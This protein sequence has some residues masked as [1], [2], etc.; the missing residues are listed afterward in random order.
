M[1][2]I[3]SGCLKKIP[4]KRFL[5]CSIC[6]QSYDLECA[7]VSEAQFYNTITVEHKNTWKCHFCRS[8]EPKTDNK[9]TPVRSSHNYESF[10]ISTNRQTSTVDCN[11]TT[12]KKTPRYIEENS[13]ISDDDET[14]SPHGNTQLCEGHKS[15]IIKKTKINLE[16]D[17]EQV[18]VQKLSSMLQQNNQHILSEIRTSFRNEIENAISEIMTSFKQSFD[19]ITAEQLQFKEDISNLNS[20]ITQLETNCRTIQSANDNLQRKILHLQSNMHLPNNENKDRVLILHG[21]VENYW[22]T[23]SEIFNRVINI[24]YDVLNLDLSGYI[25]E[26]SFIGRKNNRRPLRIELCSK[27]MKKYILENSMYLKEAGF[28]ATEFLSPQ[29]LQEKRN[30]SRSLYKARQKGHH[31]VIRNN[32]LFI[33]GKEAT[34]SYLNDESRTSPLNQKNNETSDFVEPSPTNHRTP[35]PL[36]LQFNQ[37]ITRKEVGPRRAH[38]SRNPFF[39]NNMF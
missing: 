29:A 13:R 16:N 28:S 27:R 19:K 31:A 24:F 21:L 25:D 15:Q 14:L 26:V 4:D 22:E 10:E 37:T 34:D 8:K 33:N 3:C 2:G 12:R 9:N 38:S 39:H 5:K 6:A 35:R 17:N 36:N 30:L 1:A 20:K 18:T 32:M 11:I 23:E 7:N